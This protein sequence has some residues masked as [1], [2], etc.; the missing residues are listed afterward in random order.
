MP[1]P[2][3]LPTGIW[4]EAE[5]KEMED[6]VGLYGKTYHFWQVDRGDKLPL[7]QPQL[8]MSF[9]SEEQCPG[10]DEMLGERDKRYGVSSREKKEKREY[11]AEPEVHGGKLCCTWR[12]NERELTVL[13]QTRIACGKRRKHGKIRHRKYRGIQTEIPY[14]SRTHTALG[15]LLTCLVSGLLVKVTNL[16]KIEPVSPVLFLPTLPVCPYSEFEL[17]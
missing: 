3:G 6:V 8:M 9:T 11:V 15:Y 17:E 14:R 4:E 16:T 13:E 7:G 5:T 12:L 10:F 2:Q 1:G